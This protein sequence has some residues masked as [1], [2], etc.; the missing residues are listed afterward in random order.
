M[1]LTEHRNAKDFTIRHV[2]TC[3]KAMGWKLSD[4]PGSLLRNMAKSNYAKMVEDGVYTLT[5]I[6]CDTYAEKAK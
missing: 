6:G 5:K 3:F 1:W 2:A 4:D